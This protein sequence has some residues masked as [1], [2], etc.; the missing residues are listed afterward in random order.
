MK[1][2][3]SIA[4]FGKTAATVYA[5]YD[6]ES[7]LLVVSKAVAYRQDRFQDSLLI[8]NQD[9]PA[10]D[11]HF[12]EDMLQD[13]ITCFFDVQNS[14]RLMIEDTAQQC[15]PSQQIEMDDVK[16]NGRSYRLQSVSDAQIGVLAMCQYVKRARVISN[17]ISMA[18]ALLEISKGAIYSI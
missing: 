15:N 2:Q 16:Q 4:G 9:L 14:G 7:G 3:A 18:D 12:R 17:S 1:I 8:S 6:E 5:L 10:R 11:V 13:A